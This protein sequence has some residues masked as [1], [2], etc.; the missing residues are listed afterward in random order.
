MADGSDDLLGFVAS[1]GGERALRVEAEPRRGGYVRLRVAEAERRQA[2]ARRSLCRGH[3]HRDAPQRE[4]RQALGTSTWPPR[5]RADLRSP[6]HDRRRLRHPGGHAGPHVRSAR[7]LQARERCTWT[8]WGV[9]GRGMALFSVKENAVSAAVASSGVGLGSSIKVV[10]DATQ[11]SERRDQS[12]WPSVGE[13]EDGVQSCV[14]GPHNIIRT[15]CDFALEERGTCEV[16]LGSPA[17]IAS[18]GTHEGRLLR[19]WRRPSLHRLP[20]G[21]SRARA[22]QG[23]RG[24]ERASRRLPRPLGSRC[25][26]VRRTASWAGRSKPLRSVLSRLTHKA[27]A[28]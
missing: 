14:R 12:T 2:N 11:L 7:H 21:A 16:Y 26:S 8:R 13:D 1:M 25:Q 23:R 6:R 5:A 20:L 10:T 17:E 22:P 27:R 9:H 24:R 19:R 3:R 15:C 28:R 4:G 18:H